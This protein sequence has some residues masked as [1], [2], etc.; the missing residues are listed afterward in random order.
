MVGKASKLLLVLMRKLR[1]AAGLPMSTLAT[2]L[3][4]WTLLWPA[5][6]VVLT[7]PLRQLA[8]FYGE[9][10]GAEI[11]VPKAT[12]RDERHASHI[13]E[14]IALAVRYSPSS[15][16]CYPQ[17]LVARLL[18]RSRRIPHGMFFGLRRSEA[19]QDMDAHA[20]VMVGEVPVS[21]GNSFD[22]YTVVRSFVSSS[23]E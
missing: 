22:S 21:G 12:A 6:L 8:R 17:A 19:S 11:A 3:L 16:N 20:W 18:L 23:L 14:A 15:A 5:R 13:R 10:F 2:V 1:T 4:V 7:V 9:D